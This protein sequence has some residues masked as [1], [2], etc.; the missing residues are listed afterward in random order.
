MAIQAGHV[1]HTVS[2]SPPPCKVKRPPAATA[3]KMHVPGGH[4]SPHAARPLPAATKWG[5]ASSA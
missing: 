3:V 5:D 2:C 4:V 1:R